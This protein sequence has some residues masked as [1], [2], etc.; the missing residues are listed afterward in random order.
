MAAT[1][2]DLAEAV[3]D[4]RLREDLYFRINGFGVRMPSLA[5]RRADIPE[6]SEALLEGVCAE[7]GIG[8]LALS[9]SARSALRNMECPGN[10]RQ[11]Q[12]LLSAGAIRAAGV[13]SR[14]IR[15][16]HLFPDPG[17]PAGGQAP[18]FGEA[19]RRFQ[20][21]LLAEA[22]RESGWNVTETARRLDLAR[23]HV[24]NLIKTFGLKRE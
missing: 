4:G 9:V 17:Q 19:T 18:S 7:H 15:I 1:N 13:G 2:A 3:R 12:N 5:E 6:L 10:V 8:P 22:L 24:Y 11:L 20:R 14:Q 21:D 23:S 16:G